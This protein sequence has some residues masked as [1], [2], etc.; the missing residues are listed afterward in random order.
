MRSAARGILDTVHEELAA[1][2]GV[3]E[4]DELNELL[5]RIAL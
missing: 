4:L 1:S 5:L 3:Q 2:V